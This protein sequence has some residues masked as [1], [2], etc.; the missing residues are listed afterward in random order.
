MAA[1]TVAVHDDGGEGLAGVSEG[2]SGSL[3]ILAASQGR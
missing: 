2:E 1:K 3:I